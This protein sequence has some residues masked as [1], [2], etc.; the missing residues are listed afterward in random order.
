MD[1]D[2]R[3]ELY[4]EDIDRSV[5][6]YTNVLGFNAGPS[7]YSTYRPSN[8]VASASHSKRSTNLT[9]TIRS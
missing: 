5:A 1:N 2:L 3:L 9:P 6:F 4:V 8:A 7:E